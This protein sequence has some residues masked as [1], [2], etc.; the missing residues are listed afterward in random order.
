MKTTNL[1][2][3][4]VTLM[5]T[6]LTSVAQN[7][8][9]KKP[10]AENI[11]FGKKQPPP[12]LTNYINRSSAEMVNP[13]VNSFFMP[14]MNISQPIAPHKSPNYYRQLFKERRQMQASLLSPVTKIADANL[15]NESNSAP[16]F[17]LLRDINALAES[18]PRNFTNHTIDIYD[19]LRNDSA[20][21]AVLDDVIYFVANDGI[22]GNEL[23][24]SDGTAAG[25]YMLKDLEPGTASSLLFNLTA[26][27]GKI[28]FSA[29]SSAYGSGAWVS[30]GTESGTQLLI[31]VGESTEFFAWRNKVYFIADGFDFWSTLWETDGT[32]AGTKQIIE[33]WD[34]GFPGQQIIQPTIVNGL[35]FFIYLDYET[36]GWQLW[37][38][39]LTDAVTYHVGPAYPA[40]DSTGNLNNYTPAQLTKYNKKLYFSANDGTG[41]KLWVS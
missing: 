36:F 39:D 4:A 9:D 22:H 34:K 24:R 1:L 8:I 38:S 10:A 41:R 13:N 26:A 35:L 6:A 3:L 40:L 2:L 31:S 18:N 16:H 37:R 33:L 28:Y 25:T 32:T 30:D 17:P 23:W 11:A 19:N 29:Y 12:D 7:E 14:G 27:N 20:S 21:Y 15:Q 5:L